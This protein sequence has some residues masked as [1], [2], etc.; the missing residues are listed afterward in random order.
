M[1][2]K[3][4]VLWFRF[5]HGLEDTRAEPC[6]RVHGCCRCQRMAV[7]SSRAVVNNRVLVTLQRSG[8]I[9]QDGAGEEGGNAP[10]GLKSLGL[11]LF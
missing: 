8:K 1:G 9:E 11:L 10:T 5:V 4:S 3:C 7:R 6:T 2:I